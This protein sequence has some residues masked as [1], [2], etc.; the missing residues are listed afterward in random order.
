MKDVAREQEQDDL[1]WQDSKLGNGE[2]ESQGGDQDQGSC[3]G[4]NIKLQLCGANERNGKKK[5]YELN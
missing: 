4:H 5:L 1:S 3:Y 2:G